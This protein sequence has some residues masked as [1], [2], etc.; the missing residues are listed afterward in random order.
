MAAR[1]RSPYSRRVFHTIRLRDG[2]ALEYVDLGDPDGAPVLLGHGTSGTAGVAAVI[3]DTAHA[4]GVRLVAPSRPGY[5]AS[6]A[7]LPGLASVAVDALELA[8]RLGL[9]RFAALGISG[10]GP[11]AL[12][13][14]I[15]APDRITSVIVHAGTAAHYELTPPTDADA[16]ERRAMG[17]LA[18]G[19]LEG[20]VVAMTAA[21]D[22]DFDPLR[23]L[24]A[25]ELQEALAAM[26]PA[27]ETWLDDH[28][29]AGTAFH[30]DFLRAI[31]TSAGYVRDVLSWGGAWDVDLSAIRPPVRLVAG[32]TD[33]MV[34]AAH[35]EWLRARMP[36]ADLVVVPGGHGEVSFGQ[37]DETFAMLAAAH[38]A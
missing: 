36:E 15:V 34:P 24:S 22:V 33:R 8:D 14:G 20:A 6:T 11:F 28:P 21:A 37:A 29:A 1:A 19:D 16:E 26:V 3:A 12:A 10:G 17:K 13:L 9:G 35:A 4:R 5:G 32:E 30:Q 7:S 18:A 38:T 31:G 25:T 27:G 2:R 23:G